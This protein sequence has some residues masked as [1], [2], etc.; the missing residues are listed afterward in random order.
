MEIAGRWRL[1]QN[2]TSSFSGW[3]VPEDD[4]CSFDVLYILRR[5]QSIGFALISS[6]VH[7]SSIFSQFS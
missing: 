5:L 1:V 4:T 2:S 6:R 3:S 7:A